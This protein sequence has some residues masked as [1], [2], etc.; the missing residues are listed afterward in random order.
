M[1]E[2][3]AVAGVDFARGISY[4]LRKCHGKPQR[5]ALRRALALII[6]AAGSVAGLLTRGRPRIAGR[7]RRRGWLK[8][9][10]GRRR[11]FRIGARRRI[12]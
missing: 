9:T 5:C 1:K 11:S 3:S 4:N 2:W 6:R 7:R 12:S 8:E 10:P